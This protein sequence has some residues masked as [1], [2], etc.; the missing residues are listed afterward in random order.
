MTKCM[1]A[2]REGGKVVCLAHSQHLMYAFLEKGSMNLICQVGF[3]EQT[4]K[5]AVITDSI[6]KRKKRVG[7]GKKE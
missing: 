4:S 2:M 7:G 6:K 3:D 5:T 1:F